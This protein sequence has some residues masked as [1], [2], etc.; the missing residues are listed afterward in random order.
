MA[1]IEESTIPQEIRR[2][3]N[4]GYHVP[5]PFKDAYLQDMMSI[6][7]ELGKLDRDRFGI[8]AQAIQDRIQEESCVNCHG[9]G[10][11]YLKLVSAENHP[12]L[13]MY[14]S[15]MYGHYIT[16]RDDI[17]DFETEIKSYLCPQE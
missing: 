10:L 2:I 4:N 5:H 12:D 11:A 13:H 9:K 3:I 15:K 1:C 16:L 6:F 8:C 17:R 7:I 14:F